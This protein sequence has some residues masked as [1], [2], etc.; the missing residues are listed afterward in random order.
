[1]VN[2]AASRAAVRDGMATLTPLISHVVAELSG[3]EEN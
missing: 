1:V 3:L 2:L